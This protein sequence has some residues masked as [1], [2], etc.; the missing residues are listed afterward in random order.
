MER[1][2]LHAFPKAQG[3]VV[4]IVL[5]KQRREKERKKD[6]KKEIKKSSHLRVWR[7]QQKL[8]GDTGNV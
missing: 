7:T 5:S 1:F 4:N 6:R 8:L 3:D 2:V